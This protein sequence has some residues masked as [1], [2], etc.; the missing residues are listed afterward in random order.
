MKGVKSEAINPFIAVI[1][2]PDL[3][4]FDTLINTVL[5]QQHWIWFLYNSLCVAALN[6]VLLHS[7]LSGVSIQQE[8]IE[9]LLYARS[10]YVVLRPEV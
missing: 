8:L 2:F 10:D 4:E 7:F 3:T 6:R 9:H 1:P 5:L